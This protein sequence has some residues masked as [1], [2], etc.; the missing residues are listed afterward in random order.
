MSA[1]IIVGSRLCICV[2]CGVCL[3]ERRLRIGYRPE[4]WESARIVSAAGLSG[5]R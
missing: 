3:A 4:L 5:V 2:A 1:Q